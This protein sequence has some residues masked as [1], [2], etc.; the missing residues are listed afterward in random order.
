MQ[1]IYDACLCVFSCVPDPATLTLTISIT[2]RDAFLIC[3][4]LYRDISV[5]NI[6][7]SYDG[8]SIL[9]GWDMTHEVENSRS[10]LRPR[11]FR[12]TV[13]MIVMYHITTLTLFYN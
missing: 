11:H 10:G 2:H 12:G 9:N 5:H 7:L 8:T 4:I 6:L 13:S 1:A 3:G